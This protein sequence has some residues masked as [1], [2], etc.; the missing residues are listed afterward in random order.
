MSFNITAALEQAWVQYRANVWRVLP[1]GVLTVFPAIGFVHSIALG[2]FLVFLCEG[3]ALMA[4][5][6]AVRI[7]NREENPALT[8]L[9]LR[10]AWHHWKNGFVIVLFLF[11]L[12]LIGFIAFV[13]PSIL[14]WS[15]FMFS[16]HHAVVRNKFAIDACMESFRSGRGNRI[17][18][19]WI[20]VFPYLVTMVLYIGAFVLF[21]GNGWVAAVPMAFFVP[22]YVMAIEELFEQWETSS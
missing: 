12:L 6:E 10:R 18:L 11:P 9:M 2:L 14:F 19:F 17:A 1:F 15:L 4:L 3:W 8:M 16:F 20:A 13:V 22:Y 21:D 7:T 5:T